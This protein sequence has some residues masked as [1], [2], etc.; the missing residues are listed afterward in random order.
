MSE[1]SVFWA[2][3]AGLVALPRLAYFIWG[4]RK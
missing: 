2:L 1:W 3:L 4:G